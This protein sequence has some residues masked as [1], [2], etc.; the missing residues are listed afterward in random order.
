MFAG[1]SGVFFGQCERGYLLRDTRA[2]KSLRFT[3][4][5]LLPLVTL[6]KQVQKLLGNVDESDK[7]KHRVEYL[8]S[9]DPDVPGVSVIPM[10]F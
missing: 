5:K 7:A 1:D 9:L 3:H 6:W 4:F 10:L 8:L 2:S